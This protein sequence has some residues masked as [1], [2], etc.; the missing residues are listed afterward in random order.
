ME[1]EAGGKGGRAA[2]RAREGGRARVPLAR[3]AV[4]PAGPPV[5]PL[6]PDRP[7]RLDGSVAALPEEAAIGL[8]EREYGL[9]KVA[10]VTMYLRMTSVRAAGAESLAPCDGAAGEGAR[11][12]PI[13]QGARCA[14][15]AHPRP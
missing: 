7:G 5:L 9:D 6:G 15:S 2:S 13:P 12:E 14:A 10:C 1:R 8:R 4:L 3:S 11:P